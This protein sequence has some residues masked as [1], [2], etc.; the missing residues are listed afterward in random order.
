MAYTKDL[1]KVKGEDGDVYVPTVK[2]QNGYLHFNWQLTTKENA[3]SIL[4]GTN[5]NIPVYVPSSMD[6]NGNITFTLNETVRGINGEVL[7]SYTFH[8]KGDQG[9]SGYTTFDIQHISGNIEDI[10]TNQRKAGTIYVK[11][12]KAWFYDE[13]AEDFF[14]LEGIDLSDYY[15]KSET[16]NKTEI[17]AMFNEITSQMTLAYKLLD[18]EDIINLD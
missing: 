18:I 3:Q 1:G 17:N 6:Q 13:Q 16:Y 8:V 11:N 7:Q 15:R 12:T 14:M 10:P 5:I 4:S 9:E 2:I